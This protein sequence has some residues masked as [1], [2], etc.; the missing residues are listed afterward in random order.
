VCIIASDLHVWSKYGTNYSTTLVST[1]LHSPISGTA[2]E[3]EYIRIIYKLGKYCQQ[4]PKYWYNVD[5]FAVPL[6]PG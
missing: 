2:A 5:D 4:V 3:S 6:Q 1:A